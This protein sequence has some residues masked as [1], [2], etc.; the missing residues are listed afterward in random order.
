MFP[1]V[2][3]VTIVIIGTEP[4]PQDSAGGWEEELYARLFCH[5]A[6]WSAGPELTAM[7]YTDEPL[8]GSMGFLKQVNQ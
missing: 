1:R 6:F 4:R 5:L 8:V 7:W 3:A 2:E